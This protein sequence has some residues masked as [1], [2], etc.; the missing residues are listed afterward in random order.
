MRITRLVN[1]V[2]E[3]VAVADN[4]GDSFPVDGQPY[5]FSTLRPEAGEAGSSAVDDHQRQIGSNFWFSRS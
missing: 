5:E 1:W 4:P 2:R 3:G